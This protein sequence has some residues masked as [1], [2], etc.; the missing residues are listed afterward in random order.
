MQAEVIFVTGTDTGA[1]K[2]VLTACL[3]QH[4]IDGGVDA[5]A[6]K[7]FCSGGRRD[8]KL[9]QSIQGPRLPDDFI[10]PFHF[11]EPVAPLI[12]ARKLGMRISLAEVVRNVR[13]VQRECECLI[14][15]GA[16]GVMVPLGEGFLVID[17]MRRLGGR[18]I[19]AGR[20]RLG[21]INHTVLT[22]RCLRERWGGDDLCVKVVLGDE[23]RAD[24][25]GRTNCA[26]LAE[27]LKPTEV[28]RLPF[29][30]P[31]ASTLEAVK[32]NAK[33]FKKVLARILSFYMVFLVLLKWI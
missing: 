19:V 31:K 32:K 6:M 15:E 7:P 9:L 23:R 26:M 8:V 21:I 28:F 29:L 25:S 24:F 14:V 5:L 33:K 10:N 12:A 17:L 1:G 3:L 4:L 16:G 20:N 11:R 30:G 2:T 27:L 22:V 18:A 13:A